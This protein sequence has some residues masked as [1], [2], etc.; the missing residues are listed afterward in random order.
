MNPAKLIADAKIFA[1]D[2][3]QVLAIAE[4]TK[5]SKS[6]E[7][8]DGPV[9]HSD[10]V[11]AGDTDKYRIAFKGEARAE[12]A[13]IGDTDTDLDLYVYDEN[14]IL[15]AKDD[16][17]TDQCYVAWVPKWTGSYK[18]LIINRGAVYN[19]YSILTN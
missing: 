7:A 8:V 3:P 12:I 14:N 5:I 9:R 1:K 17:N 11:L 18:V 16:D 4:K 6:R 15:I 19:N 10:Q 13:V 2:N